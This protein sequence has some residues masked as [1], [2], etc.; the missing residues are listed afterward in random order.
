MKTR[1]LTLNIPVEL[2]KRLKLMALMKE[3]TM[4]EIIL[5]EVAKALEEYEESD[6]K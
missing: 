5:K 4:T 6:K 1:T 3:T 2:H